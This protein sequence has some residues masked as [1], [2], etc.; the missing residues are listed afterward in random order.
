VSVIVTRTC[1]ACGHQGDG[2]LRYGLTRQQ[3]ARDGRRNTT[4][5]A[6]GIDLCSACWLRIGQPKTRPQRVTKRA[7]REL[8]PAGG[9]RDYLEVVRKQA[10]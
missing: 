2:V 8:L 3:A 10:G 7:L 6:G 9:Y 5:G 1:D 4:W